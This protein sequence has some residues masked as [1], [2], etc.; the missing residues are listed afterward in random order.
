ML[1]YSI[2]L[3]FVVIFSLGALA[4]ETAT[5]RYTLDSNDSFTSL[6]F[7]NSNTSLLYNALNMSQY[8]KFSSPPLTPTSTGVTGQI[9]YQDNFLYICINTNNWR[10]IRMGTW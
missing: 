9:A 10:R 2:Y 4:Q 1:K 8:L 5:T 7:N 6:F 3:S